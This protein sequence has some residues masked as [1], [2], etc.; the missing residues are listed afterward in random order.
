MWNAGGCARPQCPPL[1]APLPTALLRIAMSFA[2]F[3]LYFIIYF[4]TSGLVGAWGETSR[5]FRKWWQKIWQSNRQPNWKTDRS[6]HRAGSFTFKKYLSAELRTNNL[7]VRWIS[8]GFMEAENR[9]SNPIFLIKSSL[10]SACRLWFRPHVIR[11]G[12]NIS[13]KL[14]I[15]LH[16]LWTISRTKIFSSPFFQP[17]LF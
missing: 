10:Y 12:W 17:I 13:F 6:V 14:W 4:K 1:V 9:N 5:P 3:I 16:I 7:S 15:S 8:A 2:I 11:G